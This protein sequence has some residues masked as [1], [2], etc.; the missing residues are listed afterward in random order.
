MPSLK[1][2]TAKYRIGGVSRKPRVQTSSKVQPSLSGLR[3]RFQVQKR[4]ELQQKQSPIKLSPSAPV[5]AKT[6]RV[7]LQNTLMERQKALADQKAASAKPQPKE[8]YATQTPAR[9]TFQGQATP[10]AR[11]ARLASQPKVAPTPIPTRS[12]AEQKTYNDF[13]AAQK[14]EAEYSKI[15]ASKPGMAKGGMVKKKPVTKKPVAKKPA[16]KKK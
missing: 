2:S 4:N 14:K 3:D 8:T 13:L 1:N 10:E 7:G 15:K 11:Q 6:S 12:A 9:G 16:P 5:S